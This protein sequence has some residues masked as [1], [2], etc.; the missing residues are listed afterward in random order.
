MRREDAL[1]GAEETLA[2]GRAGSEEIERGRACSP[3][4]NTGI[5]SIADLA[6]PVSSRSGAAGNLHVAL[7]NMYYH[8]AIS[9]NAPTSAILPSPSALL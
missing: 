4:E 1:S 2:E 9:I 8:G 6:M 5:V 3:A 7:A